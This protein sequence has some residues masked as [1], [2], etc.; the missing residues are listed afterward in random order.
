VHI[1][2]ELYSANWG[3]RTADIIHNGVLSLAKHGGLTLCE[4]PPLLTNSA[5]RKLVTSRLRADVLGVAPFWGWFESLGEQ[6]RA[7]VI[8]PV[9]NKVRGL[10][11][12]TVMRSV[13]GQAEGF[14]LR[15]IFTERKIVLVSLATGDAG[16]ESGQLLGALFLGALWAT[17]QSRT[18]ISLERRHPVFVYIDEFADVMRLP[19]DFGDALAKARG[20]GVGLV[21]AH[22]HLG[23]LTPNVRA[24]VAANARSRIVFQCGYDDASTLA[25]LLGGGLTAHDLQHLA[26]YETYQAL[27]LDGRTLSPASALTLP[28]SEPLGTPEAVRRNSC[29]RF[30]VPRKETDEALIARRTPPV[31]TDEVGSRRRS[32]S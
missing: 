22:Q 24:A 8:A 5:F 18:K 27:C 14:D 11:N 21:L 6:E 25:K 9:L 17:I 10:T 31:P 26:K 29:E 3:Q 2:R 12:R 28:L 13:I 23:Q 15:R 20:L 7:A 1:L 16:S 19:Q 32:R 30:G 4:L